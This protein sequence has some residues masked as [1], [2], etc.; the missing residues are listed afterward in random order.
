MN[1]MD[2]EKKEKQKVLHALC[3]QEYTIRQSIQRYAEAARMSV[4]DDESLDLLYQN[5]HR[6]NVMEF[7]FLETVLEFCTRVL[8]VPCTEAFPPMIERTL[9]MLLRELGVQNLIT[10]PSMTYEQ[11]MKHVCNR[12]KEEEKNKKPLVIP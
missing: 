6:L 3:V 2:E 7:E 5:V 11:H 12:I 10:D 9:Q 8:Q 1:V 4:S